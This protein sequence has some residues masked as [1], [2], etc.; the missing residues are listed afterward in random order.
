MRVHDGTIMKS[1]RLDDKW[2]QNQLI[3]KFPLRQKLRYE[4]KFFWRRLEPML[5]TSAFPIPFVPVESLTKIAANLIR[6]EIKEER[7]FIEHSRILESRGLGSVARNLQSIIDGLPDFQAY[8]YGTDEFY[9]DHIEHQIRVAVLG[10]FLLFERF[11]RST[12]GTRLLDTVASSMHL[13]E[14]DV[15][16]S[17]WIAGLFH[18]I[19]MPVEKLARNFSKVLRSDLAQVYHNLDLN[20]PEINDPIPNEKQNGSFCEVLTE[21]LSSQ[22]KNNVEAAMGWHSV[23]KVDHGA[24]SA[25]LLLKSIPEVARLESG[26]MK[27]L[28]ETEYRPYLIA[29]KAIM[30]HNLY[31]SDNSI[32]VSSLENPLAFLLVCCDEMQEWGREVN[33][34]ER[35]LLDPRFRK[36][37]LVGHCLL[38]I[39]DEE[40]KFSVEYK[41]QKVK[42]LCGF[43]FDY[44][45]SDKERNIKRLKNDNKM[46]PG[47]SIKA[48][49]MVSDKDRLIRSIE[50]KVSATTG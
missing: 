40:M 50:K 1:I 16:K 33:I 3:E 6:K 49:D 22:E 24:I 38:E 13:S 41:D 42:D 26:K 21:G 45:F 14:D 48:T 8:I 27:D 23:A 17:W 44:Y 29:A 4:L 25:L 47:I 28:L 19:G 35:G 12:E 43:M 11:G 2:V 32:R 15:Q 7:T 20:V 34:K 30:L 31:K 36:A 39:S 5:G 18:D 46:F 9:R 37:K 10:S